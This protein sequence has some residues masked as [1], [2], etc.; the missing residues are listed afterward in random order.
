MRLKFQLLRHRFKIYLGLILGSIFTILISFD[1]YNIP[2]T[3]M[4][5]T[6]R[7][8]DFIFV[9]NWSYGYRSPITL[10]K[11]PLVTER[12]AGHFNIHLYSSS[13]QLDGG[14][15]FA[16]SKVKHN[17]V[18]VFNYPGD[19][20]FPIDFRTRFIKRCVG[21]PGDTIQIVNRDLFVNGKLA[22]KP[23]NMQH[24]Y[25]I[26]S[27]DTITSAQWT[28]MDVTEYEVMD[29]GTSYYA[30]LSD[31]QL[32]KL[33]QLPAVETIDPVI[34]KP[35]VQGVDSVD[36]IQDPN[37][38]FPYHKK[39]NW[40]TDYYGKLWI[41][42]EGAT[43]KLTE[44]N[45]ILYGNTIAN[46]DNPKHAQYILGQLFIDNRP[47]STYTFKQNYYWVMGD[48]RHN[49]SDSRFFGFVPENHIIGNAK[50]IWFSKNR[51][52]KNNRSF[53]LERIFLGIK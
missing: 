1:Q 51:S 38:V 5:G 19:L 52:H 23:V 36:A 33:K 49:S 42:Y 25:F 39:F 9:N 43:I 2:T 15:I 31:W 35:F 40:S 20:D 17:D 8:G 12:L 34:T 24:G 13:I 30:F 50:F 14:R 4:E 3:S 22:A 16:F 44:E 7:A 53:R 29:N 27:K 28:S 47:V 18:I 37:S 26:V 21:L 46:Y 41:P 32:E 10:L 11:I 48:N 6:L 45:L